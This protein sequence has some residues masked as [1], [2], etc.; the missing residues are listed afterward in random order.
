MT[1]GALSDLR[2]LDLT[3][4]IAGPYCTKWFADFGA[5]VVKIERPGVGD[6]A[7]SM[8]PFLHDEPGPERSGLFLYLNTNKKSI[9]LNLDSPTTRQIF[10]RL[11]QKAD[12]LVESYSP[13]TMEAWGLPYE[14]LR[15]VNPRLIMVSISNFGQTGPYRDYPATD[16]TI[17]AFSG[18][19]SDRGEAGRQPVKMGGAQSQYMAGRVAFIAT[20]AAVLHRDLTG[21]GQWLDLSVMEAAASNDLA[22]PTTYSYMGLAHR[23]RL[24]GFVRGRGGQGLYPCKDGWVAVLPGVGGLKKLAQ[25]LGQ[26]DLASH[27]WFVDHRLRLQHAQEFD[28]QFLDPWLQQHTRA[29]V[30]EK[31]Q[32]LGMPF[33]YSMPIDELMTEPQLQ[34]REFFVD[35]DHPVVGAAKY[36]GAPARLSESPWKAGRAPLLGEHNEEVYCGSLG[37]NQEQVAQLR[38]LG[39]I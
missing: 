31:A 13:G 39:V 2:V 18:I 27:P 14:A 7:R 21:E 26:P 30:V 38:E 1:E 20:M 35:I 11:V 6:S 23:P 34:A 15:D 16:L 32:E 22:S 33:S 17:S 37:Y 19:M 10:N 12:I 28:E 8:G 36:P 24:Q 25:M 3:E 29:E 4:A 5:E 9:T